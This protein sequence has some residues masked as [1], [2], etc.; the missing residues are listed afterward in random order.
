LPL[1]PIKSIT[2]KRKRKADVSDDEDQDSSSDD[3][4]DEDYEEKYSNRKMKQ[5][6]ASKTKGGNN[7]HE[8]MNL[9]M[10]HYLQAMQIP[11]DSTKTPEEIDFLIRLNHFMAERSQSHPKLVWGLRDGEF[12]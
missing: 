10:S 4:N 9:S 7:V 2:N 3:D 1:T 6:S 8:E 12:Q 5:E 11:M